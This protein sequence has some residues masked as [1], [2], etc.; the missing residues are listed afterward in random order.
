MPRQLIKTVRHNRVGG[1]LYFKLANTA[2][3]LVL[4]NQWRSGAHSILSKYL[5]EYILK[6]DS[7]SGVLFIDRLASGGASEN[8]LAPAEKAAMAALGD[9]QFAEEYAAAVLAILKQHKLT[10]PVIVGG[11]SAAA[12]A[13]AATAYGLIRLG[14]DPAGLVLVEPS[15][16]KAHGIKGRLAVP[17]A[18]TKHVIAYRHRLKRGWWTPMDR[19]QYFA[20]GKMLEYRARYMAGAATY[21]LLL[22]ILSDPQFPKTTVVISRTSH[23]H[24]FKERA[25]L[26]AATNK[27][28]KIIEVTGNHDRVC[29]PP[30]LSKYY[31]GQFD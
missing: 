28:H 20:K 5:A 6:E 11:S 2:P 16:L 8:K 3:V 30:S 26:R 27:P 25:G 10:Q 19:E 21:Q 7:Y 22:G 13:A 1:L 17:H 29:Q 24:S 14:K 31:L 15:G 18:L 4:F 12:T 23:V 9:Q